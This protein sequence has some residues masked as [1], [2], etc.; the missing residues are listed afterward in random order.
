[1]IKSH[2]AGEIGPKAVGS[3]ERQF[4]LIVQTFH[5]A[6]GILLAGDKIVEQEG[7]MFGQALR[8]LL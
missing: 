3:F 7:T 8:H 4:Q 5:N 1:M 2:F 6:A